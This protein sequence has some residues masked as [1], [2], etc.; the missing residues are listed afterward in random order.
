MVTTDGHAC[1]VCGKETESRCSSCSAHGFHI[2]FCLMDHEKLIWKHHKRVCGENSNPFTDPCFSD[3]ELA[4]FLE[5]KDTETTVHRGQRL[6]T[7]REWFI[8]GSLIPDEQLINIALQTIA[9]APR[10][11]RLAILQ[12]ARS[13]LL[14]LLPRLVKPPPIS[15]FL[16]PFFHLS[17]FASILRTSYNFLGKPTTEFSHRVVVYFSLLQHVVVPDVAPSTFHP[18]FV[19]YMLEQMVKALT[20]DKVFPTT[21]Q[22]QQ[23]QEELRVVIPSGT[24]IEYDCRFDGQGR[25]AEVRVSCSL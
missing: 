16:D 11:E 4:L 12:H 13:M 24:S 17:M 20:Q 8:G 9:W 1:W 21:Q 19:E 18:Q 23:F 6:H 14:Y 10:E 5:A 7:L 25:L 3:E 22:Q 2:Y 15:F